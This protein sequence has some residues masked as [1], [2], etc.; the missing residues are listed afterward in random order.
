MRSLIEELPES[1]RNAMRK[2]VVQLQRTD[3][4]GTVHQ[5]V[6]EILVYNLQII[7]TEYAC[8]LVFMPLNMM[9]F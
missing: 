8:I 6:N 1:S 4:S 3:E 7:V 2:C 9:I 5:S